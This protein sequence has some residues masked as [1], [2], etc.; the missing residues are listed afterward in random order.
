MVTPHSRPLSRRLAENPAARKAPH[1]RRDLLT[2]LAP[3][4]EPRRNEIA[5]LWDEYEAASTP[6]ARPA[7]ALDN[8]ET[9]L[10]HNPGPQP[11][12]L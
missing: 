4:P 3:L 10:Q 12:R 7:K 11:T 8:L 2:L 6:E 5:A 9:I 1:G